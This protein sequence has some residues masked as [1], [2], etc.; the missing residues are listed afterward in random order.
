[1]VMFRL[2]TGFWG[3]AVEAMLAAY[4]GV[5]QGETGGEGTER[6]LWRSARWY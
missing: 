6:V 2:R 3:R 5:W 1:V 4:G